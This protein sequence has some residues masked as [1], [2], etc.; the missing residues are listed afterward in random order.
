MPSIW[1]TCAAIWA[2]EWVWIELPLPRGQFAAEGR[3]CAAGGIRLC[4]GEGAHKER[5]YSGLKAN[6]E[7]AGPLVWSGH[8]EPPN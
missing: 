6:V 1:R 3:G 7:A 5:P 4:D 2:G 8:R